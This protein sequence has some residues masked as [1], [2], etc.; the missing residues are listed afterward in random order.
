MRIKGAA[1]PPTHAAKYPRYHHTA[2]TKLSDKEP[3]NKNQREK[4][5][6]RAERVMGQGCY[7]VRDPRRCDKKPL[8]LRKS[9][10]AQREDSIKAQ[11]GEC[12]HDQDKAMENI[13]KRNSPN[14]R[15]P[16]RDDVQVVTDRGVNG[17]IVDVGN[18]TVQKDLRAGKL[19]AHIMVQRYCSKQSE[20]RKACSYGDQRNG[21]RRE[22]RGATMR[23]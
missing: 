10:G 9:C 14:S 13:W 7:G 5:F 6:L 18:S 8:G 15:N 22:D 4:K 19:A 23:S 21:R 17:N 3:R 16:D 11:C 20:A 1:T 12:N 2:V